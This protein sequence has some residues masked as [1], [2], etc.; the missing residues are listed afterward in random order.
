MLAAVGL[1]WAK[2]D[3]WAES[4]NSTF[5][6]DARDF[7]LGTGDYGSF[8]HFDSF[9]DF[10]WQKR[11][12]PIIYC[13]AVM[14]VLLLSAIQVSVYGHRACTTAVHYDNQLSH[15]VLFGWDHSIQKRKTAQLQRQSIR[16][17]IEVGCPREFLKI[18]DFSHIRSEIYSI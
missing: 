14:V 7:I 3:F 11:S 1:Y 8:I 17:Q 6:M 2:F 12:I 15:L 16:S 5:Q 18:F 13:S 4:S 9:P 10:S